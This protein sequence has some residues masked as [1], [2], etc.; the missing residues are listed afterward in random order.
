MAGKLYT[1]GLRLRALAI[2]HQNATKERI[3][4]Q[5]KRRIGQVQDDCKER[6]SRL[7]LFYMNILSKKNY[8]LAA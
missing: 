4:E 7:F 1:Q 8:C 2:Y 6:I 5:I 3:N